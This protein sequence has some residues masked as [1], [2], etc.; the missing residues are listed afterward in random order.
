[1]ENQHEGYRERCHQKIAGIIG[2]IEKEEK[3]FSFKCVILLISDHMVSIYTYIPIKLAGSHSTLKLITQK[4][5]TLVVSP[6]VKTL[7]LFIST[8]S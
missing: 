4:N 1:M 5:Y 8:Y 2:G 6:Q 7:Y 3:E